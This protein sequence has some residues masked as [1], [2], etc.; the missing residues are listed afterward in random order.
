VATLGIDLNGN[1]IWDDGFAVIES[2]IDRL[3]P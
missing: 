2:W 1:A 3:A